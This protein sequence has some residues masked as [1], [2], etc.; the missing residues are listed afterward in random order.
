MGSHVQ[1][2]QAEQQQGEGKDGFG[3]G[4][5]D[6]IGT[7]GEGMGWLLNAHAGAIGAFPHVLDGLVSGNN[8]ATIFG[9]SANPFGVK[10]FDGLLSGGEEG[11][12]AAQQGEAL[13]DP[14]DFPHLNE[15]EGMSN[16][17]NGFDGVHDAGAHHGQHTSPSPSPAVGG[18]RSH[19]FS[20]DD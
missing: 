10:I 17:L 15:G 9:K 5:S 4:L 14:N 7:I 18:D 11:D 3:L 1:S 16:A 8:L 6:S 13:A 19:G 2:L 12:G 20:Y